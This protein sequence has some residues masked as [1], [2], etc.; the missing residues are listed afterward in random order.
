MSADN[1]YDQRNI[2]TMEMVYGRGYLSAGGDEE[3]AKIV[4]SIDLRD[5]HVLDLGCGLGGA[6][7]ALV[8]VAGASRIT[9]FDIDPVVLQR[10][11]ALVSE[12]KL[13]DTIELVSGQPG[14]L[15][16]S[17]NHFDVVYM[18]A[19]SCH[20]DDLNAFFADI[21]RVL[22]PDGWLIG[23]EWIVRNFNQAFR[24][25]DELLRSR[26]LNF[27]F[28]QA[29]EFLYSLKENNFQQYG[30]VD[31]T[32]SFAEYSKLA[33]FR[34]ETELKAELQVSLGAQGYQAFLDWADVRY[35]AFVEDGMQQC[36]F[37]AQKPFV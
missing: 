13:N 8:N 30:L 1:K 22:K 32:S 4:S 14:T 23:S 6:A 36:H 29:D 9:G 26:G 35:R 25:W 20:L 33:R 19:V 17:E 24:D 27:Y 16:F 37:K 12:K 31:R 28:K 3:V 15:P 34:V 11:E 10:A 21:Y 5:K 18:T 7:V 2:Q